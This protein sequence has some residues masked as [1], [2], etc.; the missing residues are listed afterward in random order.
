LAIST[1]FDSAGRAREA[2]R[3]IWHDT[4]H[5]TGHPALDGAVSTD[6]C[7][8]GAG[9][10]GLTT[11]LLQQRDGRRVVVLEAETV[12]AGATGGTSAHVTHVPDLRYAKMTDQI[13]I[14]AARVFAAEARAAF[15]TMHEFARRSPVDCDWS[16]VP[17][18]LYAESVEDADQLE[19]EAEAA[20]ELGVGAILTESLPLLF[21]VRAA[22]L[23]PGQARFHPLNYLEG[24]ARQF[25]AAG[26]RLFE[27]T[28]VGDWSEKGERVRIESDGGVVDAG[29]A[30]LATHVPLGLNVL[31]AQVA[32]YQSYVVALRVRE[33]VPDALYWDM[34]VPYH[35]LRRCLG[36]DDQE[37]LLVGG[38]DRKS[39]HEQDP[40]MCYERLEAF[41]R[42]RFSV[43]EVVERWA[44]QYY[45]PADG[46][47]YVGRSALSERVYVATGYSGTGLVLGTLAAR[48]LHDA[49]HGHETEIAR[50]VAATRIQPF[51][52]ARKVVS[53][54]LDVAVRLVGDRLAGWSGSLEGLANGEG[55]LVEC[56][57]H[58]LAV[59]RDESGAFHARS[60]V[61]THMGCIVQWNRVERTWD[62]PCHGGRYAPNGDVIGGPPLSALE[63][64]DLPHEK[65]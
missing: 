30:V 65:H 29:A 62:C 33:Q 44:A 3:S 48:V 23:F 15:R 43:R 18:Y 12:G 25:T 14:E 10:S 41:A 47:P 9:I 24:L 38:E 37:L 16:G 26:G 27:H 34:A 6:V 13:G 57:G 31:Q 11:A 28:R 51:A 5:K 64:R 46:L 55:R 39:G 53:E 36:W 54:N 21:P 50:L 49:L 17:A 56:D 40:A 63:G 8:V 20:R 42:T 45:E 52:A 2:G 4:V 35:Y 32:P 19:Q 1:S 7:V 61:C 59:Y 22:I 58:R 60:P